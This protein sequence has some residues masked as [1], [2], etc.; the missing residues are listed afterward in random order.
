MLSSD[1]HRL[2]RRI[3]AMV[4]VNPTNQEAMFWGVIVRSLDRGQAE[5]MTWLTEQENVSATTLEDAEN[6]S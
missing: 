2:W 4:R 1:T 3:E 6:R 5:A